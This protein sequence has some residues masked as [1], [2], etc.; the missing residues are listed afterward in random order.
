MARY[1][2]IDIVQMPVTWIFMLLLIIIAQQF[3]SRRCINVHLRTRMGGQSFGDILN[4]PAY[5]R[6]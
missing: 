2:L 6:G 5:P 3:N 1:R 4:N